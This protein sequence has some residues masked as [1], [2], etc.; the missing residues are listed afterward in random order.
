[1]TQ[2]LTS[3]QRQHLRRLAHEIRPMVQV[4]KQGLTDG[5]RINADRALDDHELVKVKFLNFQDQ[6]RELTEELV[7]ATNSVLISLVGNIALLYR[8]Q[9]DPD[10][11]KIELPAR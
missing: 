7:H 4:G 11:R 8:R 3:I 2:G 1:M 9:P 5:V 10:R 6:K